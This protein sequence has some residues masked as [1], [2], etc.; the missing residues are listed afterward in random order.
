MKLKKLFYLKYKLIKLEFIKSKLYNNSL[1]NYNLTETYLKKAIFIIFQFHIKNKK[2]LFIGVDET[3]KKKYKNVSKHLFLPEF[4]WFKGLLTNKIQVFK[5]I[6][7][8]QHNFMPAKIKNYFLLKKKP[9]LIVLFNEQD[10]TTM[11]KEAVKLKIPIIV[12]NTKQANFDKILYPIYANSSMISQVNNNLIIS[13]LN[14][15]FKKK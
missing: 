11:I 6:K 3:I 10:Q 2:I 13:I 7:K 14:S 4:Y 15:I 9:N 1:Q 12:L 8:N 5:Y